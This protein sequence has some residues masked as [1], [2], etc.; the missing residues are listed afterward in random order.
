LS[1]DTQDEYE[2]WKGATGG[3]SGWDIKWYKG[4]G[5]S[6]PAEGKEYFADLPRHVRPFLWTGGAADPAALL[7]AFG[8]KSHADAR[9]A[10]IAAASRRLANAD[11]KHA[12]PAPP[13]DHQQDPPPGGH[14]GGDPQSS[15]ADARGSNADARGSTGDP[16]GSKGEDEDE[17]DGNE[18]KDSDVEGVRDEYEFEGRLGERRE[19][20]DGLGVAEFVNREVVAYSIENCKRHLP[21]VVDGFKPGNRKIL[22]TCFKGRMTRDQKVASVVGAV[23]KEAD[24]HHGDASCAGMI[25]GLAQDYVGSNNLNLLVPSGQFGSRLGG[26]RDAASPRYI[27]TRLHHLTSLMFRKADEPLLT[28]CMEEGA[29]IEPHVYLPILPLLLINGCYGIGT[30]WT[31][32][33][34]CYRPADVARLVIAR[35]NG[36]PPVTPASHPIL[37]WVRG[38][39]GTIVPDPTNPYRLL[40]RGRATELPDE[41]TGEDATRSVRIDELPYTTNLVT[42]RERLAKLCDPKATKRKHKL[43]AVAN[44]S[45]DE[46]LRFIVTLPPDPLAA[47]KRATA[48]TAAAAAVTT[49]ALKPREM[50]AKSLV[51]APVNHP[52]GTQPPCVKP[53][54][55]PPAMRPLVPPTTGSLSVNTSTLNPIVVAGG[56]GARAATVMANNPLASLG[57]LSGALQLETRVQLTQL[58]AFDTHGAI[59]RYGS[60]HEMLNEFYEYRLPFYAKRKAEM[61]RSLRAELQRLSER[62]RFII[63]V[64]EERIRVR[65]TPRAE[66]IVALRQANFPPLAKTGRAKAKRNAGGATTKAQAQDVAADESNEAEEA[67]LESDQGVASESNA[68]TVGSTDAQGQQGVAE[69]SSGYDYLLSMP[70]WSLTRE[71]VADLQAQHAAKT[72]ELALVMRTLATDVWRAEIREFLAAYEADLAQR[73]ADL[74]ASAIPTRKRAAKGSG[75]TKRR[76]T[77]SKRGSASGAAAGPSK[78][79]PKKKSTSVA[80]PTRKRAPPPPS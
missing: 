69:G 80:A 73:A 30:G 25:V 40:V 55:K 6:T 45:T 63:M 71:R 46:R 7:L 77:P 64:I 49:N 32:D 52:V 44:E 33:V 34:P 10:W 62:A 24:Y 26:G 59:R 22:F 74:A 13:P 28:H 60:V 16:R 8:K 57:G 11:R 18:E 51:K 29:K 14:R 70:L 53:S 17:K 48:A 9:K 36:G 68:T 15:N 21:S 37:P 56:V 78:R 54:I 41:G 31:S 23:L 19:V 43:I 76:R 38:Y 12:P 50:A 27:Y 67:L 39:T 2:R 47:I 65:N 20:G 66:L 5:T 75:S 58:V 42:Y 1:F 79:A 35:L 4:L 3:G 72:D 61:E